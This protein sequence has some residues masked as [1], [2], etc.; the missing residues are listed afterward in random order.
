LQDGQQ[1]VAVLAAQSNS[2]FASTA[3]A[4]V[5]HVSL[6]SASQAAVTYSILVSGTAVLKNQAGVAVY[7]NGVWKV[8]VK[9]FCGLLILENAGKTAGLPAACKS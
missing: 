8:G 2:P 7:Q 5:S 4:K 9:S 1:F 3:S 6:T